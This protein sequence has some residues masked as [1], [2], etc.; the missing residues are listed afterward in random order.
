MPS[1]PVAYRSTDYPR[2]YRPLGY[3]RDEEPAANPAALPGRS[4]RR[5]WIAFVAALVATLALHVGI[6]MASSG[7]DSVTKK[8]TA[9]S[10]A[11]GSA[12]EESC[13]AQ[14]LDT[15]GDETQQDG[16]TG[17]GAQADP[18]QAL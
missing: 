1:P 14:G 17:T 10:S 13:D 3:G 9:S 18:R 4:P 16:S 7:S 6:A 12:G 2:K 5:R 8:P 15:G 11:A